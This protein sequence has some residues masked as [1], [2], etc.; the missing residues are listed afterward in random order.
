MNLD[1]KALLAKYQPKESKQSLKAPAQVCAARFSPCGKVLAAGSFDGTVRRWDAS[2]ADP[3]PELPPLM[4]HQS[5]VQC[6]AFAPDKVRLFSA[7]S[8]GRLSCWAYAE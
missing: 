1:P 4:G 8:W 3:Y 6:I 7:D 2:G 5:W